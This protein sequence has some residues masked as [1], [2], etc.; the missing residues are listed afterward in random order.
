MFLSLFD[1]EKHP[2][3]GLL[4]L[5]FV[6]TKLT[7]TCREVEESIVRKFLRNQPQP[8][9]LRK[10]LNGKDQRFQFPFGR[11]LDKKHL[12]TARKN[13]VCLSDEVAFNL[14][15]PPLTQPSNK[16]WGNLVYGEQR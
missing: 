6:A 15:L 10:N 5:V 1:S 16:F 13:C 11:L 4:F 12:R 8:Q 7:N 3:N 2:R 14:S 9:S